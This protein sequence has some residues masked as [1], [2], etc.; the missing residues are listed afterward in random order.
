MSTTDSTKLLFARDACDLAFHA[1]QLLE[2]LLLERASPLAQESEDGRRIVTP[3]NVRAVID[4]QLIDEIRA[5][6][7]G[8]THD[9]Q[10]SRGVAA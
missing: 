6:L 8:L 10:E 4:P 3:D 1:G 7:E 9:E 2:S 5:A